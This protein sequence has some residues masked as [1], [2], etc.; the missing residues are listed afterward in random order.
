[1]A[2]QPPPSPLQSSKPSP[3]ILISQHRRRRQV[4]TEEACYNCKAFTRSSI[5]PYCHGAR[6]RCARSQPW[7]M[8][9]GILLLLHQAQSVKCTIHRCRAAPWPPPTLFRPSYNNHYNCHGARLLSD[10]HE[11]ACSMM[12]S[13]SCTTEKFSRRPSRFNLGHLLSSNA[14]LGTALET[15]EPVCDRMKAS[16]RKCPSSEPFKI[17]RK[18]IIQ[19][20]YCLLRPTGCTSLILPQHTTKKFYP[21]ESWASVIDATSNTPSSRGSDM[22][23]KPPAK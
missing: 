12:R 20:R 19:A 16:S 1:M 6:L 13:N 10:G 21:E 4:R 5:V 23:V 9:I 14:V 7:L 2:T 18:P 17:T 22:P 15:R 3:L 8:A 11:T